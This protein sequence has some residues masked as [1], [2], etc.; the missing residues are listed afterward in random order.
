[1]T[2]T[3]PTT[4]ELRRLRDEAAKVADLVELRL[5]SVR[6]PDASGALADR[7]SPVVITCRPAWEGGRFT[8][9]EEERKRILADALAGG[10][11]YVDIELQSGFNDLIARHGG[12][13]V[14]F[15]MHDFNGVPHD[16]VGR[17]HSMKSTGAD[18]VKVAVQTHSLSD[19]VPLLD[20]SAR[21]GEHERIVLLGMGEHG[22]AT[23]VLAARF[24]SLWTYA[25]GLRDIGQLSASSLLDDFRFRHITRATELYGVVGRSVA[26][27]VS[28]SMHN[29]A[30]RAVQRDA[31]YLPLPSPSADDFIT[32]ARAIGLKGAS[33]TIP[34]KVALFD[35]LQEVGGE[36]DAAAR[37]IG[38]INTVRIDADGRWTATNTD[39][40]G[41]LRPLRERV[42]AQGLRAS[43]LGAGGAARAV[44]VALTSVGAAVTLHARDSA[45]ARD[46][47]N[48]TGA[49]AGS[50]PPARGSWDLLVNCTPVGTHPHLDESPIAA[51][52]LSGRYVYDLVYNPPVTRLVREAAAA[53]C[54]TIGGLEM[55]VAQ[56]E[57]QFTWW[58]GADAPA[59]VMRD[60]AMKQLAESA[61]HENYVV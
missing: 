51:D 54:E 35:R 57:E 24:G 56:A 46:V 5:D 41:F 60:A 19:C 25:G 14:V 30:F 61:R 7:R 29:A 45:K 9:S 23:R 31:V 43:V 11:E 20:L 47:A 15:S 10:A 21:Q 42:A 34:H 33:V 36:I 59:G 16:L 38:A 18:V 12:R 6:D 2:V 52:L 48:Q 26:H 37:R 55:L 40:S 32:F 22:L 1:V 13:R 50:W 8:G 53:G 3:A 39:A 28:P 4:F 17:F 27:S 58:T 49:R 44:A